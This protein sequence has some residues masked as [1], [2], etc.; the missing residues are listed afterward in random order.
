MTTT[1]ALIDLTGT[2][3]WTGETL[4][5]FN[6]RPGFREAGRWFDTWAEA[7]GEA[8]RLNQLGLCLQAASVE[9]EDYGPNGPGRRLPGRAPPDGHFVYDA[10]ASKRRRASDD[11]SGIPSFVYEWWPGMD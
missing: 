6:R 10:E 8:R 3:F 9:V 2:R 1:Y 4:L 5:P 11:Q 7:E